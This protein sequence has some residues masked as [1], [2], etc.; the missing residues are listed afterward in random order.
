MPALTSIARHQLPIIVPLL[1]CT[2]LSFFLCFYPAS[3]FARFYL[4]RFNAKVGARSTI[5]QYEYAL[6]INEAK[7][8]SA[9]LNPKLLPRY[10]SPP[11]PWNKTEDQFVL[12]QSITSLSYSFIFS[13][14]RRKSEKRK[15]LNPFRRN[16]FSVSKGDYQSA[17]R[18]SLCLRYG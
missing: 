4:A 6:I 1:F 5:V 18:H 3:S 17:V 11:L 9:K 13:Q 2:L 12:Q 15:T 16:V 14:W 10:S 8:I 7:W